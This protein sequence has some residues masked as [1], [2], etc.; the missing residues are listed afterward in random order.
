MGVAGK[1]ISRRASLGI[2]SA[3]TMGL[4]AG[5]GCGGSGAE[6]FA[7]IG[8]R[9]HNSDYIRTALT[10]T[11][12]RD[13]GVNIDFT[14]DYTLL[15]EKT[16]SRYKLLIVFRDGLI[17]PDGYLSPYPGWSP[18]D[19]EPPR[20]IPPLSPLGDTSKPWMTQ[21]QGKAVR[22]F[23]DS[24]GSAFFY[25]NASHISVYNGDFRDVQG[26][27]FIGHPAVREFVV[28]IIN[29]N[30][31]ITWG[32]KDFLVVDE[33]HYVEY[34]KAPED[35]LMKSISQNDEGY[36]EYGPISD[37]GWA[38]EYGNG[39]VCFLAPGHMISVLWNLEYAKLQQNA[40]A[41]LL[42]KT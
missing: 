34:Q 13:A 19:G 2:M 30:H 5:Q 4:L 20:S 22:D 16:L 7:L 14:D 36:Q 38:Y 41:W 11:L 3:G 10:K 33:Q 26:S 39:R 15:S 1:G 9:Y 31:P 40:A 23:V 24:G 12:V 18:R 28:R 8:D 21:E 32:V 17:W 29:N 37:A 35:L 42:R 27:A 25:H 6:A